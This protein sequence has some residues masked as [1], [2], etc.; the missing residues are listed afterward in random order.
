LRKARVHRYLELDRCDGVSN[1]LCGF[2]ELEHAVKTNIR[3]NFDVLTAGEIPP[4]PVELLES[5]EFFNLIE[6]LKNTY[7]YVFIDTPPVTVVTDAVVVAKRC[8]GIVLVIRENKTTFDMLDN[9]ID[10]IGKSGARI[11]GAVMVGDESKVKKYKYY[12]NKRYGHGYAKGYGYNYNYYYGD[13]PKPE[14]VK[15][16]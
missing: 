4:N 14:S 6:N 7:D 15:K 11:I 10:F 5:S 3:E 8:E 2:T 1:I 13:E 9:T 12:K 16:Q